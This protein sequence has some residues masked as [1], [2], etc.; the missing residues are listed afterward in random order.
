MVKTGESKREGNAG[1]KRARGWNKK[2]GNGIIA[3]F[4]IQYVYM[5]GENGG[6]KGEN[7]GNRLVSRETIKHNFVCG[8]FGGGRKTAKPHAVENG[9]RVK[10]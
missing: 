2:C 6:E 4:L 10:A 1:R 8:Y 3:M 7:G 5:L 9:E